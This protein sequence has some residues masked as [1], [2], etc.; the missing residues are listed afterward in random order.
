M[1]KRQ[2]GDRVCTFIGIESVAANALIEL[3]EK[4][5]EREVSFDT[6]A[7]YGMRVVRILQEQSEEEVILLL[8]RKYQINMIENYSD[9]FE[10]DF[11][12]GG[13]GVF[14][15]KGE[16]KQETL[17]ALKQYFRYTMSMQMLNAFTSNDALQE[18]GLCA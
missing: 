18:L 17:K 4:R 14:R 12:S 10:A 3:L 11:S 7:R 15:L 9:F 6:L 1:W 5:D 8:S 16:D 13:Q 2:G